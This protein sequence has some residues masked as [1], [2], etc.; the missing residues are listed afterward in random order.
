VKSFSRKAEAFFVC[1][2]LSDNNRTGPKVGQTS[3]DI[4]AG[5]SNLSS[6]WR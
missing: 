2:R 3:P 4:L 5:I 1:P 6:G